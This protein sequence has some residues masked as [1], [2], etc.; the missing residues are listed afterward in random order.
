MNQETKVNTPIK[1]D[2]GNEQSSHKRKNK[3]GQ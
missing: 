2:K 1:I 3:N